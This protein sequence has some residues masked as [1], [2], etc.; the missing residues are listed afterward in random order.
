[1]RG[2]YPLTRHL[3]TSFP[4]LSEGILSV[5]AYGPLPHVRIGRPGPP[6]G[7]R[8]VRSAVRQ[9]PDDPG[10]AGRG[11]E[12]DC[13]CPQSPRPVATGPSV[14]RLPAWPPVTAGSDAG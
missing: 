3:T 9:A 6:D 8:C 13:K 1:T 5:G 14:R 2:L 10:R 7:L 12:G 11:P 4:S